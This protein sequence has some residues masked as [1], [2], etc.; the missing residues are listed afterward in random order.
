MT[1]TVIGA[2]LIA[3]DHIFVKRKN[4]DAKEYLGSSGGGSVGNT[5][6]L[7]SLLGHNCKAFGIVGN[8]SV[9]D[10]IRSDF[11]LF[12]VSHSLL[13]KRG[14]P[15]KYV[16]SRQYSHII[17]E[18]RHT[19]SFKNECLS[20]GEHFTRDFQL[21][22][23]DLT[24][25]VIRAVEDADVVHL[26]RA[27][28]VLLDLISHQP[29][30]T[31]ASIDLSYTIFKREF[32]VEEILKRVHLAKINKKVFESIVGEKRDI[33]L[34]TWQTRFP[35]MK[36]VV[37]TDGVNGLFGYFIRN[38]KVTPFELEAVPSEKVVDESGAGDI[39]MAILISELIL[40][41]RKK[42]REKIIHSIRR[43]Q[44][45]AALNCTLYGAR[46]LQ[47]VFL[48]QDIKNNEIL[49]LAD[50]IL[51]EGWA[52][53]RFAPKMGL[54]NQ[55]KYPFRFSSE[56]SCSIC[57]AP[58]GVKRNKRKETK[59]SVYIANL[60]QSLITMEQAFDMSLLK[61]DELQNFRGTPILFIGSGG[62]LSAATFGEYLVLKSYGIPSKAVSPYQFENF[63]VLEL[64]TPVCLLSYGGNNPDILGASLR[65][66]KDHSKNC[67]VMCGDKN[68]KLFK[69]AEKK[70]WQTIKLP[71]QEKRAFVSTVGMLA[72][73]SS[74]TALL[75]P[76]DSIRLVRRFFEFENLRG[77][78]QRAEK[79]SIEQSNLI[80]KNIPKNK[81]HLVCVASGWG[82]PA[83][84]DFESK[85]VEGG[86][87]TIE[88]SEMKNF[89]HGRYI[90]TFYYRDN[91][92]MIIFESPE[93]REL[94]LFL[95][96]KFKRYI[97]PTLVVKTEYTGVLGAIELMIKSLYLAWYIGEKRGIDIASPRKYPPEARG[98]YGWEP[99]YRKGQKFEKLMESFGRK[100]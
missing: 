88:V 35:Q 10:I 77:V 59:K 63:E 25:R 81:L 73:I 55:F 4:S 51:D 65:L 34:Q 45:L 98:L 71:G 85:I 68:S 37:V 58:K 3:A 18:R 14:K 60:G 29:E 100:K 94:S 97:H 24:D 69:I 76:E 7:L 1:K 99:S 22:P 57:G 67:V 47:R 56:N 13:V 40:N 52:R 82:M 44:A 62:S 39:L 86:V 32:I 66:A 42:S 72:M 21:S 17:D 20:C 23:R 16:K 19:H 26:D 43:G 36:T 87:C 12:D 53:N 33:G 89:T 9:A 78:I 48:R 15:N 61:R 74:L 96:K 93:E 38:S 92:A 8:N 2:G 50:E 91:R 64:S 54:P 49:S 5:L 95:Q 75:V 28:G 83:L 70:G 46:A 84:T 79:I 11:D 30:N 90:N 27:N 6:C 80:A 31:L 41:G